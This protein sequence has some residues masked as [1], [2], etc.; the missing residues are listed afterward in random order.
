MGK[1]KVTEAYLSGAA[2]G[3]RYVNGSSDTYTPAQFENAIKALK[4]TLV[5]KSISANGT[6]DPEDDS[7]DGYD[8]VTVAV[9]NSYSQSDEGKVVASGAL[10]AQTARSSQITDNGTYDTTTN[11]S[12]TVNVSGGGGGG[13][14][15]VLV[16][17]DAPSSS[18]GSEGDV[19]I[20][21]VVIGQTAVAHTYVLTITEALRGSSRL[22]YAGATELDLVFDDGNGN[23]V[24][25]TSFSDFSCT[26]KNANNGSISNINRLFDGDLTN[27]C[28]GN[29]TPLTFYLSATI[30]AGYTPKK[31]KVVRRSNGYDDVWKD[32]TLDDTVAGGSLNIITES[33]LSLSDWAGTG[34]WTVFQCGQGIS[35]NVPTNYYVKGSTGWVET[36][37]SGAMKAIVDILA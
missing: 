31:L 33:N 7:A 26:G 9:P 22:T 15:H 28:E 4:K 27:Y 11:N 12:V 19:Y 21:Y 34:T 2:D 32:F 20:K 36:T 17:T 14:D 5:S 35:G 10:V 13:S 29:P 30:P 37:M 16:G 25:I 23:E 1:V 3:I 8:G 18:A 24:S 6:Y